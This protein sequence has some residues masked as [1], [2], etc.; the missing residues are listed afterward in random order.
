MA[1][2]VPQ[3]CLHR[4]PRSFPL[5]NPTLASADLRGPIWFQA[6][7][8][9]A[10]KPASHAMA[11]AGLSTSAFL[12]E[13]LCDPGFVEE[14]GWAPSNQATVPSLTP[15]WKLPNRGATYILPGCLAACL[16]AWLPAW[17]AAVRV[18]E[19]WAELYKRGNQC[20]CMLD[21]GKAEGRAAS[22]APVSFQVSR[23]VCE[24]IWSPPWTTAVSGSC[25][26]CC[27][28]LG[29]RQMLNQPLVA[30]GALTPPQPGPRQPGPRQAP[31]CLLQAAG[32]V[33]SLP[34]DALPFTM[35][36]I[37]RAVAELEREATVQAS[38]ARV[39][40]ILQDWLGPGG[41]RPRTHPLS[42]ELRALLDRV[43]VHAVSGARERGVVLAPDGSTVAVRPLLLGL[44]AGLQ[45]RAAG[46]RLD[47]HAE[48]GGDGRGLGN[49]SADGP[50]GGAAPPDGTDGLPDAPD[51]LPASTAPDG[52]PDAPDGLTASTAPDGLLASAAPYGLPDAPDGL[53][54]AVAAPPAAPDGLSASAAPDGLL[55]ATLAAQLGL[56]FLQ[57][58]P[59][60]S[61]PGLGTEGCWDRLSDP[62]AFTL[63][64]PPTSPLTMAFLNGALDGV[65][66]G[67][68]LRRR[69]GPRAAL[70]RLLWQYYGAA[71]VDGDPG[72][73][74]NFRRQRGAALLSAAR[75]QARVLGALTRRQR[76]EPGHPQLRLRTREQ[77][78]QAAGRAAREFT[79]AY[80]GCPAIHPRC[81]WG[82]AP[83]RGSPLPL[84][85]PLRFLYVHHTFEPSK[86][87]TS[88]APCAANMRSMQRF[89]QDQRSWADLGYSF[90]VGSDGYVYEGRG[91]HWVGAHTLG[92]NNLGFGV[93]FIGNYTATLPA[94]AALR[95]VRDGLPRCAARAGLLHPDYKL[96]GHRQVRRGTDCPGDA[97]FRLLGT[98]PHFLQTEG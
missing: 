56:A 98:W 78:A 52:L 5:P 19:I 18:K 83:F 34:L 24:V 79:E 86:P 65:L 68:H 61:P 37:I 73:R 82:A 3:V 72:L 2:S 57:P 54:D 21:F 69:P 10:A 20:H 47:G 45:L 74:S 16:P 36:A 58:R 9:A 96:L 50:R 64:D 70:G 22:L 43:S 75:L 42:P 39:L 97:L 1:L 13:P 95:V 33:L 32:A 28:G 25:L 66:L 15:L 12:P 53:P 60:P 76:L 93:A 59:A 48:P 55:D 51:G 26:P 77:L 80:L 84:Q 23:V 63:L 67:D 46:S 27:C 8:R 88:F 49:S 81:R 94:E 40:P 6:V 30:V 4:I 35:D 44:M 29:P 41:A 14:E 90:V 91:W 62:Q 85:L 7:A 17:P 87:C 31:L 38:P 92:H 71:G 89:H 11:A